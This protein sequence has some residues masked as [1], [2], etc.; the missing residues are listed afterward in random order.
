MEK[1]FGIRLPETVAYGRFLGTHGKPHFIS[2]REGQE[3]VAFELTYPFRQ[4]PAGTELYGQLFF[5]DRIYG[6]ITSARTPQGERY[7]VCM[8]L[9]DTDGPRGL[10]REGEGDEPG[11]I[12]VFS[13]VL[14]EGVSLFE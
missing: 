8:Q 13:L 1:K 4:L 14:F 9:L 3:S 6:R 2:I 10:L 11:S 5:S 7:P 12:R